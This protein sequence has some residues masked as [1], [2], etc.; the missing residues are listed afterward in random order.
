MKK[1]SKTTGT[2]LQCPYC[3]KLIAYEL[4]NFNESPQHLTDE[5]ASVH[6]CVC[7]NCNDILKLWVLE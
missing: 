1:P 5:H 2:G 4:K 6:M 7:P 3:K